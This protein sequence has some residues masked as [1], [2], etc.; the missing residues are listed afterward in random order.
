MDRTRRHGRHPR[1][2]RCPSPSP[3]PCAPPPG[4]RT[5]QSSPH[6]NGPDHPPNLLDRPL[7]SSS[8][9]PHV[10]G[11]IRR[12][13]FRGEQK[14]STLYQLETLA[15]A[16]AGAEADALFEDVLSARFP[17][18]AVVEPVTGLVYARERWYDPSTGTFLSPDPLGTETPLTCIHLQAAIPSIDAI[19]LRALANCSGAGEDRGTEG[20]RQTTSRRMD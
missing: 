20:G 19:R 10:P 5:F 12:Q 3:T 1:C 4:A 18:L 8:A 14:T 15:L 17:G 13:H 6:R 16:A 2:P 9:N 7:R 11:D